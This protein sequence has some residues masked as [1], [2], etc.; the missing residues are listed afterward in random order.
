MNPAFTIRLSSSQTVIPANLISKHLKF[1][2]SKMKQHS[3][4]LSRV[5]F[6]CVVSSVMSIALAA[7]SPLAHAQTT[8]PQAAAAE[9]LTNETIVKLAGLKLGDGLIISK[10]KTSNCSFQTGI[11]DMMKLK[12][13]GVS[14]AVIQAM[15]EASAAKNTVAA[16][17]AKNPLP[18]DPN[19][20]RSP[21]D[22]GVYWLPKERRAK[23][24]VPLEPTVYSGGKSG[25][26]FTSALTYGIAKTK[27]KAVVRGGR[28]NLRMFEEK[29]KFW[30]YFEE[31]SH[32]LSQSANWWAGASSPN[33]FVLAK[34]SAKKDE[35]EL[36]VS[37]FNAFGS[38]KGTQ[39][40]DT[41]VLKI[42]KVAPG[43]YRVTPEEPMRPGEYCFFYAGGTAATGQSGG[44]LFD[45]GVDPPR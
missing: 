12:E 13:A 26:M 23:D 21:H 9:T 36:V 1:E 2:S 34:L 19:D 8:P 25:G 45:F 10:I 32:G 3:L 22:P 5:A 4:R 28:A 27:W 30:F 29:P 11:E 41:V 7:I 14:D 35:R 18:P 40:K 42:E 39:S 16:E 17:V 44:K 38:S 6:A 24:M 43:V 37:Q 31:K 15:V 20:P 33:E